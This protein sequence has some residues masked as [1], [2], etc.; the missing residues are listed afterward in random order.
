MRRLFVFSLL[1]FGGDGIDT[2]VLPTLTATGSRSSTRTSTATRTS[3][4]SEYY[5]HTVASSPSMW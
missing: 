1:L 5:T 4:V 2:Q 3:V